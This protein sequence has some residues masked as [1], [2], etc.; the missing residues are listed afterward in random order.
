[1]SLTGCRMIIRRSAE[2]LAS[3]FFAGRRQFSLPV[4]VNYLCRFFFS[5]FHSFVVVGDRLLLLI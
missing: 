5:F 3:I 4:G 1:M 2:C